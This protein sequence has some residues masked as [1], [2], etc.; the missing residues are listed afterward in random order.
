[1][2]LKGTQY[3]DV[4]EPGTPTAVEIAAGLDN[5]RDLISTATRWPISR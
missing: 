4:V 3:G 5:G 1:M 2:D